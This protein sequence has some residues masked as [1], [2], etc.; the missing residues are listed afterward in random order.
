M[1]TLSKKEIKS[2]TS[3]PSTFYLYKDEATSKDL[4]KIINQTLP[5][6]EAYWILPIIKIAAEKSLITDEVKIAMLTKA[7]DEYSQI[8]YIAD[9]FQMYKIDVSDEFINTHIAHTFGFS[10]Y[11]IDT[12]LSHFQPHLNK[13]T[14]ERILHVLNGHAGI[15]NT[16]NY[17]IKQ[18]SDTKNYKFITEKEI[19]FTHLKQ[20]KRADAAQIVEALIDAHEFEHITKTENEKTGPRYKYMLFSDALIEKMINACLAVRQP[21]FIITNQT[22]WNYL[23]TNY[24]GEDKKIEKLKQYKKQAIHQL[25]DDAQFAF[26]T[27]NKAAL[28]Y[29]INQEPELLN[30][31]PL[32]FYFNAIDTVNRSDDALKLM[33]LLPLPNE[34][35]EHK[36]IE[37]NPSAATK[38]PPYEKLSPE[39]QNY[40]SIIKDLD[41]MNPVFHDVR[42]MDLKPR[43]IS[44]LI[45]L[46]FS[47]AVD[48]YKLMEC[49]LANN[50]YLDKE[51][52]KQMLDRD[53]RIEPIIKKH[54]CGGSLR[55]MR[56][57]DFIEAKKQ[58]LRTVLGRKGKNNTK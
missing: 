43:K 7:K 30:G 4:I 45:N 33:N 38:F 1:M 37:N 12:I 31:I 47:D 20:D 36:Y 16:L 6:H 56:A 22:V 55:K 19:L 52:I 8:K 10:H 53:P 49:L 3:D 41:K 27:K 32:A 48:W 51:Y 50:P 23:T 28:S 39:T 14:I 2:I 46:R 54:W 29:I 21:K 34:N 15:S 17:I 5:I 11:R 26:L 25:F 35:L 40:I 9:M 18:L 44:A 24:A 13:D 57:Q 58:Q 42:L